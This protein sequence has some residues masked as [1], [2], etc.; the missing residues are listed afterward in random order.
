MVH[1]NMVILGPVITFNIRMSSQSI[2]NG[3]ECFT[4][5]LHKWN[6][7]LIFQV[8]TPIIINTVLQCRNFVIQNTGKASIL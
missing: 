4:S 2:I 5:P 7:E 8:Y 3:L 6:V 1:W